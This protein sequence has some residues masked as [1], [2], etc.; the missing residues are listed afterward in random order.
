MAIEFNEDQI[1]VI[2]SRG[3]DVLVSAAAGSG[4][5]AV[6]VERIVRLV[7]EG[8]NPIDIDRLLVVTFTNAAAAEM[9]ERVSSAIE[10]R[11][12]KEPNNEHLQKQAV[13]VHNAH[14]CTI[15]SFCGYVLR[16]NFNE[17]DVEPGY[18]TP[19][20]G[21]IALLQKDVF[22]ELFEEH[23]SEQDE[24]KRKAFTELVEFYA[25]NGN[26][27]ILEEII[28]GL[29]KTSQSMAFPEEWLAKQKNAV[30]P[31]SVEE[32]EQTDYVQEFINNQLKIELK[33]IR[34][35]YKKAVEI[36]Q[37]PDGPYFYGELLEKEL[38]IIEK[39]LEA[40]SFDEIG[41]RLRKIAFDRLPSAK[42]NDVYNTE[43][44]DLAQGIRGKCKKKIGALISNE[45]SYPLE[46]QMKREIE[47]IKIVRTLIEVTE[48]FTK[49]YEALKKDKKLMEFSDVAHAATRILVSKDDNGNLVPTASA[50]ELGKKFDEILIDEYQDT[51]GIQE[52]LLNAVCCDR[53]RGQHMF[54]VGDV[55]Q[56]IYKFRKAK[57]ELFVNK[58][59][60]YAQN[61]VGKER[62]D[63][64]MNFR[65]RHEVLRITNVI[66]SHI[67]DE[68]YGGVDYDD[69]AALYYGA[70]YPDASDIN[71]PEL[72][73]IKELSDDEDST[74]EQEVRVIARR[75]KELI[76]T[77]KITYKEKDPETK[78][79]VNKLRDCR[80]SDIV[81]LL[82]SYKGWEN[83][84]R[85]IFNANGI[86]VYIQ[87]STG[88]FD[89]TEVS[90]VLNFLRIIDNPTRN[91]PMFAALKSH[92]GGFTDEEIARIRV[93]S[94]D[95][96]SVNLYENLNMALNNDCID[97]NLQEKIQKFIQ[98]L[99]LYRKMATYE[100][101]RK[102]L[103]RIFEDSFYL[104]YVSALPAGSVRKAN[105]EMLLVKAGDFEKTSYR[106]LF[107]FIRY[108]EQLQKYNTEEGEADIQ[109]E[110]ADV[111]RIMTIHKSKGLEFPVAII[112]GLHKSFNDKDSES[113]FV[114]DDTLGIASKY[115]DSASRCRFETTHRKVVS[116][117]I[118]V[119]TRAERLR[120]LYVAMTRAKEKLIMTGVICK[121]DKIEKAFEKYLTARTETSWRLSRGELDCNSLLEYI[122]KALIRHPSIESLF[123]ITNT[124]M[125]PVREIPCEFD[126]CKD[127][128]VDDI[129]I[130]FAD[131][132]E[133]DNFNIIEEAAREY[134]ANELMDIDFR[135]IHSQK[136][137]EEILT[138][139]NFEYPHNGLANLFTKTS[140]SE[141]K[142]AA[143][144]EEGEPVKELFNEEELKP[145]VPS[146]RREKEEISGTTR[147][148]AF[149]RVLELL[150]FVE[151]TKDSLSHSQR[152]EAINKEMDSF[153]LDERLTKEYR[154]AVVTEKIAT[155]LESKL[156][157]RMAK[158][159]EEGHLYREQPFVYGISATRLNKDFP[160]D[161]KILIQGI[162]D[163]FFIEDGKIVLMDYKTDVINEGKELVDRYRTQL[164]YYKEA[165]E[166][167]RG[168]A[169]SEMILYSFNL[170]DEIKVDM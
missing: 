85:K 10:E 128:S 155:F 160:S 4:K 151:L 53:Q 49:K 68:N 170:L 148:S 119:D 31:R 69:K 156:A 65:S 132:S 78:E 46:V 163:A 71:K 158:A 113:N 141:L 12:L 154:D 57:P 139:F 168:L 40:S 142:M 161:E 105:V 126:F 62:I 111:V 164:D 96:K 72:L 14:I 43:L 110:N 147:G 58:Y 45:F 135:N 107:H 120:L 90:N 54:M 87:N 26:D 35:L 60:D 28:S 16:N 34:D 11:I 94:S 118:K 30:I 115:M 112:C 42:K 104:E 116:T 100:S 59:K 7:S 32:F 152:I 61:P 103:Y 21:E 17:V 83:A 38:E 134:T 25:P 15:D 97:S 23:Y 50:L 153:V 159:D 127:E 76:K 51:N 52:A 157:K 19:D 145:Y 2:N 64:K 88:Y 91:V 75:I 137:Y 99:Q 9:R 27:E 70:K 5:T 93:I 133:L 162:I 165:L 36:T 125:N 22:T 18:R 80:F 108:I 136:F 6:L 129:D 13:L 74:I 89:T 144:A 81:I 92:F 56:S 166:A 37:M 149:H 41:D 55:K 29:Y 98:K 143:L 1:N 101:V 47:C 138:R 44:K 106:G 146:F 121:E 84:F 150:D 24:E 66:F 63:L 102:L 73:L 131:S 33:T 48:D 122:I 123:E 77:Q 3:K 114:I 140:V 8:D 130:R 39:V 67:M 124:Q 79:E 167:A 95:K 82:S 117:K 86:P 109:E 20:S 169:V